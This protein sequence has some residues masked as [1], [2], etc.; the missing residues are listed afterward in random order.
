M[1]F[2][3]T[4]SFGASA[5]LV[6]VGVRAEATSRT[7][8]QKIFA[9]IPLIFA[10]QQLVEGMLWLSLNNEMILPLRSALT[11]LYLFFAM[12]VWPFWISLSVRLAEKNAARK[13]I[14]TILVVLGI[15]VAVTVVLALFLYPVEAMTPQCMSCPVSSPPSVI[16]HLHYRFSFSPVARNGITVFTIAYILST[17]IPPFISGIPKM[18]WLGA[19][20]LVSYLFAVIFFNGFVVSVWC[21]FAAL[22][23]GMVLWILPE[24]GEKPDHIG[25]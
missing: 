4:A 19:G 3:A 20:F 13:R 23:S 9:A 25:R 24:F 14:L 21:F 12:A 1:C 15:L 2:S 10:V 16:H 22:L 7:W 6:A 17:I 8:P 18:K 11:Y 5:V